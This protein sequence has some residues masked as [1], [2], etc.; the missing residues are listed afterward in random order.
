MSMA[1]VR[2]GCTRLLTL[3]L[4]VELS[5]WMGVAGCL[6]PIYC[7]MILSLTALRELIYMA[8]SLASAADDMTS[9]MIL[10]TL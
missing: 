4:A 8:P 2:F 3:P 7:K 9:L 10:A 5:T 6:C 1:L